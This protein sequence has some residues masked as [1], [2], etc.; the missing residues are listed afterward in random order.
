MLALGERTYRYAELRRR[1]GGVSERMLASTL[2]TLDED[3]L[4]SRAQRKIEL[5]KA[6]RQ[7][8]KERERLGGGHP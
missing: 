3:G 4:V 1:I 6:E 7:F 5:R 8:P 2:R